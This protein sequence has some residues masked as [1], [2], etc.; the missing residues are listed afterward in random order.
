MKFI[1]WLRRRWLVICLSL[2]PAFVLGLVAGPLLYSFSN[3]WGGGNDCA[4]YSP[5]RIFLAYGLSWPI[6]VMQFT[7]D[8][9]H[10]DSLN[11]FRSGNPGLIVLW[12]YYY[13]LV[14]GI[15]FLFKLRTKRRAERV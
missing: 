10:V 1:E 13:F 8:F 3:C 12:A 7:F 2:V 11:P 15:D 6:L 14:S 5:T 9:S 4:A